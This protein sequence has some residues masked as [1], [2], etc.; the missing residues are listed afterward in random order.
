MKPNFF[1]MELAPRPEIA[2]DFGVSGRVI[3]RAI[4][5]AEQMYASELAA[6]KLE[7]YGPDSDTCFP[8]IGGRA[9]PISRSLAQSAATLVMMQTDNGQPGWQP[10]EWEDFVAMSVAA[11]DEFDQI[12]NDARNLLSKKKALAG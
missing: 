8:A 11:E 12:T 7:I 5:I 3:L 4:G 10:W 9:V 1:S 2:R 6:A